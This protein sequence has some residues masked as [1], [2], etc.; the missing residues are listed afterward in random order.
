M[1]SSPQ[2]FLSIRTIVFAC[3]E[4]ANASGFSRIPIE[5]AEAAP[6]LAV[7]GLID[8]FGLVSLLVA[9]EQDLTADLDIV[10]NLAQQMSAD[11]RKGE[12]PLAT[13]GSFLTYIVQQVQKSAAVHMPQGDA[14]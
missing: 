8:S 3:I 11:L 6:I 7:G 12:N 14:I 5:Q 10:I 13:V 9:I 2:V 4:E 1:Q